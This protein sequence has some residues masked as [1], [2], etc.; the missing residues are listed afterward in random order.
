MQLGDSATPLHRD[1]PENLLAQV[2]GYKKLIMFPPDDDHR[3]YAF[4][5]RSLLPSFSPVDAEHPDYS[6]YPR[7]RGASPLHVTLSPGEVL[8]LPRQWWHQVRSIDDSISVNFWWPRGINWVLAAGRSL[9]KRI[10]Q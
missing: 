1:F 3:M 4:S 7:M 8:Y 10:Q 5:S 9:M 2:V 6:R